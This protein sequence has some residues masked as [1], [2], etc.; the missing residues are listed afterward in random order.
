[1]VF[2]SPRRIFSCMQESVTSANHFHS[3]RSENAKHSRP[4]RFAHASFH[5]A[6][7]RTNLSSIPAEGRNS[8]I[9]MHSH[10]DSTVSIPSAGIEP[11][12]HPPQGCV[13]SI[14]RRGGN[15]FTLSVSPNFFQRRAVAVSDYKLSLNTPVFQYVS[16]VFLFCRLEGLSH[17][18]HYDIS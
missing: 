7:L 14:E 17:G 13:L 18:M 16:D 6:W 15:V 8:K 4:R 9:S 2:V 3:R 12:L 11:T 1:M 10:C 5:Y